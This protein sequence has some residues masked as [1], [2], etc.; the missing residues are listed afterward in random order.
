MENKEEG[1]SFCQDLIRSV[2]ILPGCTDNA[3]EIVVI[4]VGRMVIIKA[5]NIGN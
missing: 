5:I 3:S 2:R 4:N 1:T